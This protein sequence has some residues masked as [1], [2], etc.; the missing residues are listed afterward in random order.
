M[1]NFK[2]WF[3]KNLKE[4]K[5]DIQ[6]HGCDGGFPYITYTRDCVR[7]YNKFEDE[8][9]DALNE[10]AEE[11]GYES[12]DAFVATFR[13]KDMLSNPDTRKNLLLWYM[14]ERVANER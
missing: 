6:N 3:N 8:I 14:V 11:F 5:R 10:D 9:Y 12:V 7:L 4:Y 13:R 2:K 1:S